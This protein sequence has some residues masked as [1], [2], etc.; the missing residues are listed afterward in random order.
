MSLS[1]NMTLGHYIWPLRWAVQFIKTDLQVLEADHNSLCQE[2]LE[3]LPLGNP[4]RQKT[5]QLKQYVH[6]MRRS[7]EAGELEELEEGARLDDITPQ[8]AQVEAS[9]MLAIVLESKADAE[10][11]LIT[12]VRLEPHLQ[13]CWETHQETLQQDWDSV[14]NSIQK[15]L[16]ELQ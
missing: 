1:C 13:H 3:Q 9:D 14:V 6:V 10:R 11:Q 8:V 2:L 16:E 7:L 15:L 12:I 4:A 5:D